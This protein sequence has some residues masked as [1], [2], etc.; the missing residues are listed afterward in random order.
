MKL[1]FCV[2]ESSDGMNVG[3][4]LREQGVSRRMISRLK[5]TEGGIQRKGSLLRTIDILKNGE[6]VVI[7]LPDE[8]GS[9]TPAENI[10]VAVLYEDEHMILF[11]KPFGMPVHPSHRHRGDT[12]S[13]YCLTKY[14]GMAFHAVNRLDKDTSGICVVAKNSFS[15]AFLQREGIDKTYLAICEATLNRCTQS[16]F[17][18]QREGVINLPIAREQESIIRRVV[19]DDGQRAVTN[20]KVIAENNGMALL[21]ISLE[22][23]RTHQIRVHFSHIGYPLVGDDLYGGS[24]DKIS[25]Q[26]LHCSKIRLKRLDNKII[27]VGSPL[28]QDMAGLIY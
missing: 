8:S 14:P 5:R 4:F 27:E 11:D 12:L 25:R 26:A 22:T 28:P 6:E 17:V 2:N 13:D 10:Q 16:P 21:E 19:R 23:G 15:A 18:L 7:L 24:R 1:S 9:F 3:D 20:Y